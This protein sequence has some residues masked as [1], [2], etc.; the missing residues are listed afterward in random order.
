M[1]PKTQTQTLATPTPAD[2]L[3]AA[4]AS[5][6]PT[7]PPFCPPWQKFRSPAANPPGFWTAVNHDIWTGGF[8]MQLGTAPHSATAP[9]TNG[10]LQV[11]WFWQGYLNAGWNSLT[12]RFQLGPVTLR[13]NGGAVAAKVYANLG[14]PLEVPIRERK[15]FHRMSAVS[16]GA[17]IYLTINADLEESG[18]YKLYLGGQ[19]DSSYACAASPYA[20]II[21]ARTEVTH[22]GPAFQALG[23]AQGVAPVEVLE[24]QPVQEKD[25]KLIDIDPAKEPRLAP[26]LQGV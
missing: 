23:A 19:L 6:I 7:A 25:V 17:C 2:A 18:T 15:H 21:C 13:A 22:C 3:A 14:G 11:G 24:L 8:V 5:V 1:S 10:T 26:I 20:E 4:A 12:V 16:S 9:L